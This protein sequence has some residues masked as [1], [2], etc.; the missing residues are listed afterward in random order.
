MMYPYEAVGFVVHGLF[1]PARN[2]SQDPLD[3]FELDPREAALYWDSCDYLVHSH[4]VKVCAFPRFEGIDV[5][6][7]VPSKA[8][9]L[10]QQA[11]D[12][13]W[14][15]VS[16]DGLGVSAP[17][18]W[19]NPN[20]RPPLMEREFVFNVQ[21]C[22]SLT[23]DWMYETHGIELPECPRDWNWFENGERH[24]DDL[25]GPW[26]FEELDIS[27][28]REGDLILFRM[29]TDYTNHMGIYLGGNR[30]LHHA[31]GQ[32]SCVDNLAKYQRRGFIHKI[33][34]HRD[35]K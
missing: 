35:I 4:T 11:M 22:L 21:D 34:R 8:D 20:V 14:A 1:V 25:W 31:L 2:M 6:P 17:V 30:L 16:C 12:K 28:A 10:G 9:M 32:L 19:G 7:R 3:E 15:V 13:P 23:A 5:D 29:H 26:G 33:V 27:Q 24:I 18:M